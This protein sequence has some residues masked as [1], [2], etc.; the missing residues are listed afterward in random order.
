MLCYI[1][2]DY[3]GNPVQQS[4]SQFGPNIHTPKLKTCSGSASIAK[5]VKSSDFFF[6]FFKK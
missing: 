5:E 2:C 4:L 6:F 1:R 3:P